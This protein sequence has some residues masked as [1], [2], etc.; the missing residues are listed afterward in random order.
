MIA[1]YLVYIKLFSCEDL[2]FAKTSIE[3]LEISV[4]RTFIA[5]NNNNTGREDPLEVSIIR[6]F[7]PENA[8]LKANFS[9][10]TFKK[11][12]SY[13]KHAPIFQHFSKDDL[14][15]L[16]AEIDSWE[17]PEALQEK[18]P[19]YHAGYDYDDRPIWVTEAGKYRLRH[20]TEGGIEK[21][22]LLEKYILKAALRIMKSMQEKDTKER[23]IRECV[24]VI[25][26]DGLDIQ[27]FMHVPTIS[28]GQRLTNDYREIL[29]DVIGTVLVINANYVGEVGINMIRPLLG[30]MLEKIEIYGTNRNKWVPVLRR[31]LPL[32]T[33]PKWY[34]GSDKFKP[35]KVYGTKVPLVISSD[36]NEFK[37][38]TLSPELLDKGYNFLR[39][40]SAFND[41][42][43][44]EIFAILEELETWEAPEYFQRKFPYYHA[45]FDYD[46]RPFWISELGK[47]NMR[48]VVEKGP[49]ALATF[50][51]YVLQAAFYVLKSIHD[52]NTD[53]REV[54]EVVFLVDYD[55]LDMYQLTHIPTVTFALRVARI[56]S[57]LLQVALGRCIIINAN[58]VGELAVSLLRPIL[59]GILERVEI[60]GTNKAKW[61]PV[62]KK[63]FPENTLPTPLLQLLEYDGKTQIQG[64]TKSHGKKGNKTSDFFE[65]FPPKRTLTALWL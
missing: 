64:L 9:D 21:V 48:A 65:Y 22:S 13:V 18:F 55:G 27:Q 47:Y 20:I 51:K 3:P 6:S 16:I 8:T 45:G 29:A 7:L 26:L 53:G 11:A 43:K 58:Y 24:F 39:R 5:T 34:G 63:A 14:Y 2:S 1:K 30:H 19:Y 31:I 52:R 38:F 42:S 57:D 61:M 36:K 32:N 25:D 62:L 41:Y 60:Y 40:S 4:I 37:N 28:L 50:D 35:V 12:Y 17:V 54:S 59:G 15:N 49:E 56:Y 23:E 46:D 10:P 44:Q 33:I